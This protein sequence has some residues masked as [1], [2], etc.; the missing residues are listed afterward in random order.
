MM[1]YYCYL[2]SLP[3]PGLLIV[4]GWCGYVCADEAYCNNLQ[5]RSTLYRHLTLPPLP[6]PLPLLLPL[7][8]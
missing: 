3:R 4:S 6:L 7:S 8:C 1:G 5:H 2:L